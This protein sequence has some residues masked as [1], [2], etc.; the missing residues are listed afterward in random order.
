MREKKMTI[1]F[2]YTILVTII[3]IP[4]VVSAQTANSSN[5]S[6]EAMVRSLNGMGGIVNITAA[7]SSIVLENDIFTKTIRLRI[8]RANRLFTPDADNAFDL[9]TPAFRWRT[10]HLGADSVVVHYDRNDR[11]GT[12]DRVG[13]AINRKVTLGFDDAITA[14]LRADGETIEGPDVNVNRI[15][16][17]LRLTTTRPN[18]PNL[19][20]A[21]KPNA[22][23]LMDGLG[24]V[25]IGPGNP[26]AQSAILYLNPHNIPGQNVV[27][28]R[29]GFGAGGNEFATR[30]AQGTFA[31]P[32]MVQA[33]DDLGGYGFFGHDGSNFVLAADIDA[34]VD[35]EPGVNKMPVALSF[36]TRT[37][38][39][40]G[41]EQLKER[42][43]ITSDGE[44]I[45]GTPDT[46]GRLRVIG[47]VVAT[48]MKNFVSPH[49]T[50]PSKELVYVSLEGPEAGT[51]LRGSGEL[52]NGEAILNLAE[53]FSLVTNDVG[54]TV[55]LTPQGEWLQLYVVRKTASQ[56]VVREATGKSGSFDY[57]V[58]GVR[59]GYENHS[60]I[61]DRQ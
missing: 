40:G 41:T 34:F 25:A 22:G 44:A 30:K 53:H 45:I 59:K 32:E 60:V 11:A 14:T 4:N 5:S 47:D 35:G 55:Q 57:L 27:L 39:A 42:L 28:D 16:T 54:L 56:I 2:I 46:P 7:D 8:G 6:S 26:G 3:L 24:R 18:I 51:Y 1:S 38:L 43:R 37:K 19:A 20:D 49:P 13:D 31:A 15:A 12:G 33:G 23:L 17:R 58:Q 36:K 29:Y 50:N 21:G 52:V 9:G 61:R 10:L 48:G